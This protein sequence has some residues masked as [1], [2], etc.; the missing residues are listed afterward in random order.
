MIIGNLMNTDQYIKILNDFRNSYQNLICEYCDFETPS[1]DERCICFN[2]ESFVHSTRTI[3][4][5]RDSPLLDSL[6]SIKSSLNDSKYVDAITVYDR[7]IKER[8]DP[9]LM[10]ASALVQIKYSNYEISMISYD[11]KGFMEENTQHR[12]MAAKLTSSAKRLLAKSIS[13]IEA[14]ISKA[15]NSTNLLYPLFLSQIKLG[16]YRGAQNSIQG[17]KKGE[18]SYLA[19]YAAMLLDVYMENY[20]SAIRNADTLLE[21]GGF[22]INALFYISFCKFKNGKAKEAKRLFTEI[23]K[24]IESDSIAQ[25]LSE[26]SAQE[27]T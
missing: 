24:I 22:S 12:D 19:N 26:I 21:K 4:E 23:S 7:L 10:Y 3:L 14:E 27:S 5:R 1:T 16:N 9:I 6:D 25:M 8:N 13:T 2:C 20:E 18:N 15:G 17:L 11:K